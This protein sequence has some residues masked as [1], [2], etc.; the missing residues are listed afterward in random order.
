MRKKKKKINKME[1]KEK[2]KLKYSKTIAERYVTQSNGNTH[3]KECSL[4]IYF[5]H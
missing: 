4:F 5:K 3:W 1:L 2:R